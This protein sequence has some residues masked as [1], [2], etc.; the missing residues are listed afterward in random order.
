MQQL[1]L[2]RG[3]DHITLQADATVPMAGL[4]DQLKRNGAVLQC[5][6]QNPCSGSMALG[7]LLR[8]GTVEKCWRS[9]RGLLS[10][11]PEWEHRMRLCG[12]RLS[13]LHL[14][15][16]PAGECDALRSW[17]DISQSFQSLCWI[18]KPVQILGFFNSQPST[19]V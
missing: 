16:L 5:P 9:L 19:L 2:C 8:Q 1:S 12:A 13:C 11:T 10:R 14:P 7:S 3:P 15:K 4:G 6:P 18:A 17:W